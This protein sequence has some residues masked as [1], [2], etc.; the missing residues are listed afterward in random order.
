M[1]E[2]F[3]LNGG[4][5]TTGPSLPLNEG[6]GEVGGG[7]EI[8]RLRPPRRRKALRIGGRDRTEHEAAKGEGVDY[9]EGRGGV[10]GEE[11]RGPGIDG[12]SRGGGGVGGMG[13]LCHAGELLID[14]FHEQLVGSAA[15]GEGRGR[16]ERSNGLR[17]RGQFLLLFE[18]SDCFALSQAQP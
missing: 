4:D 7:G 18:G 13:R 3:R 8:K 17:G 10:G 11:M 9:R 15:G 6:V 14:V 5:Q 16:G 12:H 1:T 2:K